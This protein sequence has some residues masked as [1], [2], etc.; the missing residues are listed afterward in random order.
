MKLPQISAYLLRRKM[1]SI[2]R[3]DW[4]IYYIGDV[5][6]AIRYGVTG[7][8]YSWNG[9]SD[10]LH[11]YQVKTDPIHYIPDCIIGKVKTSSD[12][13]ARARIADMLYYKGLWIP[14]A[15]IKEITPEIAY[16][17]SSAQDSK[18]WALS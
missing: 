6:I 4:W 13:Y 9:T 15:C 11:D 12:Y 8:T 18:E 2:S 3:G 5:P 10:N 16:C 17:F 1:K 14:D 7:N